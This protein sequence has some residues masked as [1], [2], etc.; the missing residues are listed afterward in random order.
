MSINLFSFPST[1]RAPTTANPITS[2]A[3]GTTYTLTATSAAI[4]F[5]TTSPSITISAP[6]TYLI[7]CRAEVVL[8]GATFAA[9]RTVTIK[10]RRTNNTAADLTNGTVT[11]ITPVVTTVSGTLA[12][13]Q[14]ICAPYTTTN[15]DDV[16]TLF[17]DV[18]VLPTAGTIFI[19]EAN[20]VAIRLQG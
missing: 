2:F 9:S 13:D 19:H 15:S 20:I 5:G 18:S 4:A 11:N 3:A 7:F 6:G 16:I 1:S 12:D 17:G 8:N 14:W 10:A